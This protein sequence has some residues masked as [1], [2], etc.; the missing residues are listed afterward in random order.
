MDYPYKFRDLFFYQKVD[1]VS[2]SYI[3]YKNIKLNN[4]VFRYPEYKWMVMSLI[5]GTLY[6]WKDEM[7]FDEKKYC[8]GADFII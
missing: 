3:I 7:I 4:A 5:N 1:I 8:F 2:N 6:M